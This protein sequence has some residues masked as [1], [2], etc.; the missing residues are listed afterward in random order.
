MKPSPPLWRPQPPRWRPRAAARTVAAL[1]ALLVTVP[2]ALPA[3][4]GRL[5]GGVRSSTDGSPLAQVRVRL[6]DSAGAIRA[7][8]RTDARGEFR[9]AEIAPGRYLLSAALVGWLAQL[10]RD[11]EIASGRTTRIWIALTPAPYGLDPVTVT[12]K[13]RGERL[14]ESPAPLSVI[15]REEVESRPA[16]DLLDHADEATG[17]DI[18]RTGLQ[19]GYVVTRGFNSLFNASLLLL[20]DHR[21]SR[22]PSLHVNLPRAVPVTSLDIERIEVLRGPGSILYGPDASE[23]VIHVLTK[24]P[25]DDPGLSVSVGGGSREQDAVPGYGAST[26]GVGE[27][28]GRWAARVDDRFGAG[29]SGRWFRGTDWRYL[30]PA[31]VE[32]RAAAAACLSSFSA[33]TPA[34]RPYE[35]DPGTLPD[36]DLLA[37]IG[38]RDFAVED[39]AL[40]GRADWRPGTSSAVVVSG[41]LER[42]VNSLDQT[43]VGVAETRDGSTWYAQA[44]LET[45]DL[46]AQAY[47]DK[48]ELRGGRDTYLVRSGQPIRD[49]SALF[50]L[51]AQYGL[52]PWPGERLTYGVDLIRTIPA[53]DGTQDGIY[54]GRDDF[55]QLG[56]YLQS[57]AELSRRLMLELGT[58]LDHHSVLHGLIASPQA[59]L[60]YRPSERHSL[61]ATFRRAFRTPGANDFFN[62]LFAQRI[63]LG[64]PFSYGVRTQGGAGS[65][66]TF[67]E[68]DGRPAMKSPFAPL[69]GEATTSYLPATTPEL[70]R[71]ARELLR[72]EDPSAAGLLD[73]AGVPQA[74]EVSPVLAQLDAGSGAF[75]PV[76]GGFGAVR[77]IPPLEAQKTNT[78]ELGY[79]G[80]PSERLLL[81]ADAYYTLEQDVI[82]A[83]EFVTPNVFLDGEQLA[84]YFRSRGMD[85]ATARAL[86]IGTRSRPGLSRLPLGV[87]QPRELTDPAPN[88]LL[89]LRNHGNLDVFGADISADLDLTSLWRFGAALSWVSDDRFDVGGVQ[90][91][92][93]APTLKSRVSVRYRD[94]EHGRYA[95]LAHRFVKG[96]P[97]S[98]GVYSGRVKDYQLVDLTLGLRLPGTRK[99]TVQ[100][101]VDDLLDA[102]Y[103]TF[104]GAPE[105][106]RLTLA[107]VVYGL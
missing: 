51:Q 11:V 3:Q 103:R 74:S 29:L 19:N 62:D 89:V 78:L 75:V 44:R 85:D 10:R 2:C 37:R 102:G 36:S 66:F 107:R 91:A 96:F 69:I 86:A 73:V 79:K 50:V 40:D 94:A 83:V 7:E 81:T 98:S 15:G 104:P 99:L 21:I 22:V 68:L 20:T 72:T 28:E 48:N 25:I 67:P 61:R 82:T 23:G 90:V 1:A 45:G 17:T 16:I 6:L 42:T 105:L 34:C 13:R 32:A 47:L 70:Y 30:D 49:H 43:G 4:S 64:G 46:F 87:I 39:W 88:L 97:A 100:V 9:V 65:G 56:G 18:L 54:E 84:A 31:E 35:P 93:N 60:V 63:P 14:L 5:A 33:D 76:P 53:T 38:H 57:E 27:I 106:G 41:G 12:E 8:V 24:S 77:D 26:G 71:L 95:A 52:Q 80:L 92:L 58:R 101:E 55:T 59:A